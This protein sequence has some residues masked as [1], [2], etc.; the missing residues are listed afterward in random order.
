VGDVGG[1]S[2]G[3][4][5]VNE[6][7]IFRD[8]AFLAEEWARIPHGTHNGY[9]NYACRCRECGVAWAEYKR[10]RRAAKAVTS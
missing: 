1:L 3:G 10:L 4:L 6:P 5:V 7:I 8:E 9:R 2:V